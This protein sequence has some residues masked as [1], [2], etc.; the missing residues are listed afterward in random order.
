MMT[1]DGKS[2]WSPVISAVKCYAL[3]L[4]V[5]TLIAGGS[6]VPLAEFIEYHD[7]AYVLDDAQI[8]HLVDSATTA[9]DRYT[10]SNARREARKLDTK[11]MYESWR[12]EYRAW[13]KR[14]PGMSDPWY[15]KQIAKMDI[16]QGRDSETIRKHMKK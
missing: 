16:A 15:S 7:G 8:R 2:V 13:R 14:R 1:V 11:A 12:K 3:K 6:K 9:D 10:P 5:L 4:L